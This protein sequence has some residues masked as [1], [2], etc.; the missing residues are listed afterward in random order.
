MPVNSANR[1]CQ[2]P[3]NL[4]RGF[5][6]FHRGRH[7]ASPAVARFR[8]PLWIVLRV[9]FRARFSRIPA[10]RDF[11]A[12]AC[13]QGL[14]RTSSSLYACPALAEIL[15]SRSVIRPVHP[16]PEADRLLRLETVR[17]A[18]ERVATRRERAYFL[19]LSFSRK[20]WRNLATFGATTAW[21][22]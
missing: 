7:S 20:C 16:A 3:A 18:S 6:I 13:S 4:A 1:G 14:I 15:V 22:Y 12:A 8:R 17:F 9:H 19:V 11:P 10:M 21:Q 2:C 5:S